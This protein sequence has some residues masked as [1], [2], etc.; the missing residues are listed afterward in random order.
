MDEASWLYPANQAV[1]PTDDIAKGSSQGIGKGISG[2]F[3]IYDVMACARDQDTY[4]QYKVGESPWIPGS[5]LN[6]VVNSGFP[7]KNLFSC[8]VPSRCD[9]GC[10][11]YTHYDILYWTA[12]ERTPYTYDTL[13]HYYYPDDAADDDGGLDR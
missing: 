7:F 13:E 12:P 8:D 6:D 9:G 4:Y 11:G 5:L 3:A 10:D 1:N 2:P